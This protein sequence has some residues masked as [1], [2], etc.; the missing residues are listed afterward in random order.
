MFENHLKDYFKDLGYVDVTANNWKGVRIYIN[1]TS[2]ISFS[3]DLTQDYKVSSDALLDPEVFK[4]A[5]KAI[6]Y[7]KIK[8]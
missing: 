2:K 3:Y 8:A 6:H 1:L 4:E 7:A 5:N